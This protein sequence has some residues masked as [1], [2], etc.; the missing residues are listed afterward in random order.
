MTPSRLSRGTEPS[1]ARFVGTP[2]GPPGLRELPGGA[3]R[4]GLSFG[5]AGPR[6]VIPYCF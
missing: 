6:Y 2:A 5:N 1:S 4:A 3:G